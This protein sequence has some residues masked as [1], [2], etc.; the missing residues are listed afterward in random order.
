[1]TS[2]ITVVNARTMISM[3]GKTYF[4]DENG[5]SRTGWYEENQKRYWLNLDGRAETGWKM[6]D[7]HKYWFF[8]DGHM[9]T[10]FRK[11]AGKMYNFGRDGVMLTYWQMLSNKRYYF[12]QDGHME[13]GWARIGDIIYLFSKEGV[14]QKNVTVGDWRVDEE[15]HQGCDNVRSG[16][17]DAKHQLGQFRRIPQVHEH[18]D[19]D[20]RHHSPFGTVHGN[21]QIDEGRDE[22]KNPKQRQTDQADAFQKVGTLDRDND[23]QVGFVEEERKL[24]CKEEQNQ[25]ARYPGDAL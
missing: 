6:I 22:D 11:I 4:F 15:G 12:N 10:G 14:L 5:H 9:E 23:A 19:E 7:G 25:K 18:G 8:S 13:T 16:I 2:L 17:T 20:R 1:M 24:R 21:K 3:N